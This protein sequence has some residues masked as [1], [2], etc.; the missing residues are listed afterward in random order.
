[1]S[2]AWTPY[3]LEA[4]RAR[5]LKRRRRIVLGLALLAAAAYVAFLVANI[6]TSTEV[7]SVGRGGGGGSGSS[8]ARIDLTKERPVSRPV[9][10][11]LSPGR[12]TFVPNDLQGSPAEQTTV[13]AKKEAEID[14]VQFHPSNLLRP[15]V[16]LLVIGWA[17][18]RFLW[19]TPGG[20]LYEA[21][22][23]IYKGALPIETVTHRF[24]KRLRSGS[25]VS[26]ELFGHR[27]KT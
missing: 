26:P 27:R 23:G 11:A 3:G 5:Y 4:L 8:S 12:V 25:E 24:A 21:N 1:M 15:A 19:G 6:E 17:V 7:S 10:I 20:S 16:P 14:F 2:Q 13:P 9:T 22:F 18:R